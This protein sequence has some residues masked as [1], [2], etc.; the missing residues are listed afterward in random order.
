M[1]KMITAIF[2]SFLVGNYHDQVDDG[3]AQEENS[4]E[5]DR[6]F[7]SHEDVLFFDLPNIEEVDVV[8]CGQARRTQ[9]LWQ[10]KSCFSRT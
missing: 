4:A 8:A 6:V 3:Y 1:G 9:R 10:S 7:L 2:C 5:Y